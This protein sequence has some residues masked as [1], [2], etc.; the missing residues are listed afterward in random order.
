MSTNLRKRPVRKIWLVAHPIG[1]FKEDVKTLAMQHN[2]KIVDAK[3]ARDYPEDMVAAKAP[4][5]TS[6]TAELEAANAK[7][8]EEA[9]IEAKVKAEAAEEAEIERKY[10][11]EVEVR[12]RVTKEMAAEA[13]KK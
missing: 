9:G 3:Y 10:R 5:L 4:K 6:I 12:A 11:L 7:A 2:L 8:A 1:Q 13:K